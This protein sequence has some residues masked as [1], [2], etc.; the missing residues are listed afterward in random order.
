MFEVLKKQRLY[1]KLEKCNFLLPE[2]SFLGYIIGKAGIR[3]DPAK[4]QAIQEWPTPTTLTQARSFHGLASF[5]RRFIKNFSSVLAPVT[6]CTK[7]RKFEWTPAAQKAFETLKEMMCKTPI[8]KLPDFAKPFELK[9]DASGVGIGAVLVQ[10]G[11]PIAFFSEKLNHSRLNYSTYDKEFYAIIRA[12][13]HWSHYLRIQPFVLHT[14][15]ESL[16]YINSQHKLSSRHARW[17]EYMQTFDFATKYKIGK[18]NIIADAL[19]RKYSILGKVGSRI[20]GFEFIKEQYSACPDFAEIYQSCKDKPQG[21]FSIYQGFL[22]KGNKLCIPKLPLRFVLVKEVHEGSIA[23]HFGI[24][25]T[26]DMLAKHFFWPKMLG[27]VGKHVLKC[28]VCLKAKVT[29]HKGE[30]IPL[31]LA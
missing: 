26:L 7:Q 13:E 16:K 31:P 21:L 20:L 25:K 17:V 29:F 14:D 4:V 10:E 18:T 9:C 22:F 5:Y 28:E 19:S 1:A 3:V 24:Q 2:V 15:H 8:L 11:R 12:F 23:G 27:T 6:K 30:Y